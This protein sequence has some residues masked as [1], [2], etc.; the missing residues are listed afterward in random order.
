M[1]HSFSKKRKIYYG[2]GLA[3]L[4]IFAGVLLWRMV[5]I[6]LVLLMLQLQNLV[7][8]GL[9]LLTAPLGII[10]VALGLV[11]TGKP[12][13]FVVLMG[14]LAL[15][16]IIIRNSV[17]LIDQIEKHR[18]EG[19]AVLDALVHGIVFGSSDAMAAGN[20]SRGFCRG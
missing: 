1:I 15:F 16:G 2:T 18:A 17:I 9:T 14:I 8:T 20:G 10:G 3:A 5:L 6:I 19:E 12:F 7:K 4:L 13:G 11:L